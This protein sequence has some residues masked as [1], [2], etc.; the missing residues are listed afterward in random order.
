MWS[1]LTSHLQTAFSVLKREYGGW[2]GYTY[3]CAVLWSLLCRV[4]LINIHRLPS[5]HSTR[6]LDFDAT[7]SKP[8]PWSKCQLT[9]GVQCKCSVKLRIHQSH[10]PVPRS[11]QTEKKN[12]GKL[13]INTM[14][15]YPS[16]FLKLFENKWNNCMEQE[17][18]SQNIYY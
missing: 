4:C 13:Q 14:P 11:C 2:A 12:L 9:T 18:Q 7:T 1:N 3:C 8:F 5:S 6:G 16:C 15:H 17:L 10:S